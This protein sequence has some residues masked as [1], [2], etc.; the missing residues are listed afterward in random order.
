MPIAAKEASDEKFTKRDHVTPLMKDL[1]WLNIQNR[2]QI[3]EASY[4]Y[5]DINKN[6]SYIK[7]QNFQQNNK[8][9]RAQHLQ[10]RTMI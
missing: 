7:T 6:Q 5:K 3:N 2:L 1:K 8:I 10:D 9:E 4:I